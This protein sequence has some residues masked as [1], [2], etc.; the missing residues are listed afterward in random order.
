M[1]RVSHFRSTAG[2]VVLLSSQACHALWNCLANGSSIPAFAC[3]HSCL[4]PPADFRC[5][6]LPSCAA[7]LSG[8]HKWWKAHTRI[9]GQVQEHI[10]P[11]QQRVV[12]SFFK[13]L[14]AKLKHKVVDN[15]H[16]WPALL[17]IGYFQHWCDHK[18][19]E[20]EK[21]QWP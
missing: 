14:P 19:H 3:S 7:S 5:L 21:E 6:L 15:W 1:L 13:D 18:Y 17:S 16:F 4:A 10:S 11:Y 2:I 12:S 20:L 9:N 8:L